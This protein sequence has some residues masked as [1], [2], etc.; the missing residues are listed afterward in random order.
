M[1]T[2]E[3][4]S[5]QLRGYLDKI[6]SRQGELE[7]AAGDGPFTGEQ[8]TEYEKLSAEHEHIMAT[9]KAPMIPIRTSG[10][11]R[12]MES[13]ETM[14][15][16]GRGPI[17]ANGG[18]GMMLM[19]END[20]V[21]RAFTPD[22]NLAS[23]GDPAPGRIGVALQDVLRGNGLRAEVVTHSDTDGGFV[24][25]RP[26]MRRLLD[27]VRS[28][29]VAVRAGAQTLPMEAGGMTFG[30]IEKDPVAQWRPEG[31]KVFASDI[32]FGRIDLKPKTLAAIVPVTMEWAEDARNG[33][34]LIEAALTNALAAELD[35]AILLGDGSD[36]EPLGL[37]NHPSIPA[38]A[39]IGTPAGYGEIVAAVGDIYERDYTGDV[40]SLSWIRHP[41]DART[42]AGLT[43]TTGQPLM[44]PE[45]ASGLRK[46][47]TT[48]LP[49][50]GGDGT[51]ESL[52]IIGDF[53]ELV[54]GMRTR[55]N[56]RF[57]RDAR[58][59]DLDGNVHNAADELKGMF[60]AY[61][62]ADV[63]VLRPQFFQK[64]TGITAA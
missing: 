14:G 55:M 22:E 53:S 4:L 30:T 16:S 29:S 24:V 20:R 38:T 26:T 17:A 25:P 46:F 62:R 36:A 34:S 27:L 50:D 41:R 39:A 59:T 61:L 63:A 18:S 45:W 28:A 19:D 37:F 44:A 47:Q 52:G 15:G 33:A 5:A 23:A 64:L 31:A 1:F 7:A 57:T 42:Y 12:P 2:R 49:A 48:K 58:V 10:A 56:I 8:R 54:I 60:I 43:D 6:D 9:G 3:Q 51:D 21:V 32:T 35:R 13:H 11:G 40:G